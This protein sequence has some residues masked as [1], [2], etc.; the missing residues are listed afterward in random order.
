MTIYNSNARS[1]FSFKTNRKR[2]V[3]LVIYIQYLFFK[4]K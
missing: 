4:I 2:T 1:L 3:I